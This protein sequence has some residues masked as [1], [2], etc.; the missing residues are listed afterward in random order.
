MKRNQSGVALLLIVLII[1]VA[2]FIMAYESAFLGLGELEAGYIDSKGSEAFS[3]ADG[4]M[5]NTLYILTKN[6]AYV[7]EALPDN[8]CII[9]VTGSGSTRTITVTGTTGEFHKKIQASVTLPMQS[10]QLLSA[11]IITSWQEIES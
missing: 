1:S 7:G 9:I 2:G 5:E 4:C 3:I 10:G 11:P 6:I 8:S